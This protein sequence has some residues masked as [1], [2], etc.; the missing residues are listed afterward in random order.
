MS[1]N[2]TQ[3]QVN[4]FG[5]KISPNADA[6]VAL[7]ENG[8]DQGTLAQILAAIRGKDVETQPAK[9][10]ATEDK[11]NLGVDDADEKP[12]PTADDEDFKFETGNKA[13]DVAV[14]SFLRSTGASDADIERAC[15]SA[16]EYGDPKLIDRAFIAEKFGDRAADAVALAEAVIEQA[17][18]EKQRTVQAVY[19]LAGSKEQWDTALG[20][21]KQ[22]APAGLQKA[23][24]IMFS[25]GDAASVKEAAGLVLE[26]AKG[27]GV[28]PVGAGQRQVAGGGTAAS[29]GL[30]AQ[31]FKAALSKLNPNAR[32]YH[33][34][35]E[36]LL[37][38]RRVGKQLGM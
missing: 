3:D 18:V 10:P 33:Q 37:N 17:G 29:E 32:T 35:Y 23:L 22:H 14:S 26:F 24:G 1:E 8:P 15:K 4:E 12:L 20:V 9:V 11:G 36:R 28:L 30:S 34:D 25:S 16:L 13:L 2:Q 31:E 6:N 27:S 5:S 38:M 7:N 21:Y 19:D